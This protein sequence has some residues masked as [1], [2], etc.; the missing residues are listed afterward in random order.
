MKKTTLYNTHLNL[1]A[2][3]TPFGGYEMPVQYSGVTK[4]HLAVRK[5]VGVFDVSHMG[6][7]MVSGPKAFGL[8]QYICSNDISKISIG[9]AQYNYFPNE[10]GG[11]VDDLIVYRLEE[12]KYLLV[13]N[14]SNIEKDWKWVQKHNV[15]FGAVVEDQSEETALLAIQGPKAI[16][17]MQQLTSAPLTELPFYSH[18]TA[19]FAGCENTLIATT[20]YTGAGGLE[21]YL[22]SSKAPEVWDAIMK[23]GA[24]FDILPAGLAAR[25]TLRLEM[26]YCLYGNEIN[27][28][29]S[30]LAAGLNWVT[31]LDTGTY[32]ADH[33]INQ[34]KE[35]TPEKLVGFVLK[36]RGIP[37]AGYSI[38]NQNSER[39]GAV[40]SGTQSPILSQGIGLGYVSSNYAKPGTQIAIQIRDK[41]SLAEV[42]KLPFI[43]N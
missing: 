2:K 39:I 7:F 40:T 20:G 38:V 9:K 41:E 13:V 16:E 35:G 31:K 17:A 34:K 22:P 21:I 29:T 18:T 33:L 28:T 25:D 12:E 30:P 36:N 5:G 43:K 4:E 42:V 19:T 32:N 10:T 6:E 14:A 37:R 11:I 24:D 3:M 15:D 27:D 26:G 1:N 23:A 8:L